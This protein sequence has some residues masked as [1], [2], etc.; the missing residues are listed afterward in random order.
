MKL[1]PLELADDL[2]YLKQEYLAAVTR[3]GIDVWRIP[4]TSLDP[5]NEP[6]WGWHPKDEGQEG[7]HWNAFSQKAF[8]PYLKDAMDRRNLSDKVII[9][10]SDDFSVW[11]GVA[12]CIYVRVKD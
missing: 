10:A 8:I 7:S 11:D 5:F 3:Y 4:F 2:L 6:R 9:T 12:V 1:D